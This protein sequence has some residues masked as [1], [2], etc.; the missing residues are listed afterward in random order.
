LRTHPAFEELCALATS[1]QLSPEEAGLLRDHLAECEPCREFMRD[2]RQ[3]GDQIVPSQQRIEE[4]REVPTGVRERFL[5]RA[6]SEGLHIEAGPPMHV[7]TPAEPQV[8]IRVSREEKDS[9]LALLARSRQAWVLMLGACTACLFAGLVVRTPLAN[10]WPSLFG[11]RTASKP[12]NLKPDTSLTPDTWN[13]EPAKSDRNHLVTLTAERDRLALEITSLTAQ[14]ETLKKEKEASETNLTAKISAT[15]SSAAQDHD[16][17]LKQSQTLSTRAADLES[18]LN[19]LRQR[20]TLLEADLHIERSKASEY[21][22]RLEI[23]QH[24]IHTETTAAPSTAF[25][26]TDG[27]IGSLVAARNLHII[28]VYDSTAQGKRQRAF[29]RVFYVEGRS[30]VFYAFDLAAPHQAKNITFHLW[31]EK[32]GQKE[33]T[34]SLGV[35]HDDD[36]A[37]RRWALTFDDPKVLAR[38]NSVYVTAE[39]KPGDQPRGPKVLYAYFGSQ[40]NHP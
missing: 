18:Q 13:L 29:G 11:D 24:S 26:P 23:A 32:A 37:E 7:P 35:L 1:G 14:L 36:P 28:D 16:A 8:Q 12:S 33:T 9:S 19:T 21:A 15:Q 31:G 10:K 27:E 39:S 20:Q 3:V 2:A 6:A 34:L 17:L 30:L 5:A 4:E 25:L 40:P 38:I 22:A